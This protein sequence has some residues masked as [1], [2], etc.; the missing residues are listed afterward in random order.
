[1][2]HT[3]I[4]KAGEGGNNYQ[5]AG[6]SASSTSI[7]LPNQTPTEMP[8]V[9]QSTLEAVPRND[10]TV[11]VKADPGWYITD[12]THDG[13][14]ENVPKYATEYEVHINDIKADHVIRS[15]FARAGYIKFN[16]GFAV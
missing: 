9:T 16:K 12:V 13:V 3:I 5:I 10:Y 4:E 6:R 1:M 11:T 8:Y 15:L 2:S 14:A 7:D